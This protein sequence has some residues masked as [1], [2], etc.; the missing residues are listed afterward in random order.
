VGK[1]VDL[2]GRFVYNEEG[3]E[4][5]NFGKYKGQSVKDVLQKDPGYYGWI[6]QSDFTLNTKQVLT[7]LRFKYAGR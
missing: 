1:S 7:R 4:I 3:V 5:V 2:A 6:M